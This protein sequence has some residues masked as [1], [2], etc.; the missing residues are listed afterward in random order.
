M[1]YL[2]FNTSLNS[3][4]LTGEK[5]V[6]R[7]K[8][9]LPVSRYTGLK[10]LHSEL[11]LTGFNGTNA[12]FTVNEIF[13][14]SVKA[15]YRIGDIVCIKETCR[16]Y[17]I[18][19]QYEAKVSICF[20]ADDSC[21]DFVVTSEEVTRLLT[22]SDSHY[23][24]SPYY[25]KLATARLFLEITDVR[26]ERLQDITEEQAAKEGIKEFHI[27]GTDFVYAPSNDWLESF[28]RKNPKNWNRKLSAPVQAFKELYNST[29]K[30]RDIEV[31]DW[32]SN[33]YV[34][35]IEFK[36]VSREY[37]LKKERELC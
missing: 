32:E 13:N 28:R 15:P 30:K 4:I 19:D 6:T 8:L 2:F 36:R 16:L 18:V 24:L 5:T 26:I 1:K 37:A 21:E 11:N 29:L 20:K 12:D 25:I 9:K 23:W 3:L 27:D 17:D 14:T 7:R 22:L 35:V 31:C 33:P 34:W 10:P